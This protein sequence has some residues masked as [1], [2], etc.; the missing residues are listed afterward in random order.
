LQLQRLKIER[1]AHLEVARPSFAEC[2]RVPGAA[3][4]RLIKKN[5]K[6]RKKNDLRMRKREHVLLFQVCKRRLGV[7]VMEAEKKNVVN[8]ERNKNKKKASR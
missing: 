5:K 2:G 3:C 1:V 8:K 7:V 4:A 6:E